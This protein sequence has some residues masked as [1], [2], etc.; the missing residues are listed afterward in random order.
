[1]SIAA[2]ARTTA[3]QELRDAAGSHSDRELVRWVTTGESSTYTDVLEDAALWARRLAAAGVTPGERVVLLLP[4]SAAFVG[5]LFGTWLL[6]AVAVPLNT[7]LRGASLRHPLDLF[8]PHAVVVSAALRPILDEVV[9][10]SVVAVEVDGTGRTD[11]EGVTGEAGSHG[12][13]PHDATMQ[14]ACLIMSTSGTTGPSKGTVWDFGTLHQWVRTY[15]EHLALGPTDRIYCCTPLFH[16][17]S[18]ASGLL[19]ALHVGGTVVVAER[20]SVS[21]FWDDITAS[22]ATTAN[23]LGAMVDLLLADDRPPSPSGLRTM[24]VS[25]CSAR[26]HGAMQERWGITPVT[27]YGLT[28]FGTIVFS[29]RGAEAPPGSVGRPVDGYEVRLVD[30][31]DAA[32]PEG[33]AGELLVRPREAWTAPPGYFRMPE[34]T[35]ES[36]RGLWFHTGDLLRVDDGWWYYVGRV[37]DSMRRRGENVSAHEVEQAALGF[38]PVG[39]AAAYAVPARDSEDDV[40]LAVVLRAGS[41]PLDH[42]AFVTHLAQ[43][44]PYFAVPRFIRVVDALPKTP[45]LRV[46][47]TAL[48]TEGVTDDTWDLERS[49]VTVLRNPRGPQRQR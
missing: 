7:E 22:A 16:A 1:M 38:P 3:L 48:R 42:R 12:A 49:D 11:M 9:A 26:S 2:R 35:L 20:F 34:Q 41:A 24:L 17:N 15:A 28:D 27:A 18:L 44:L 40:A 37:T 23:L 14:D 45:T 19:T 39:E 32:V 30:S 10:S 25:S 46:Q 4:N 47:K 13:P 29:Q 21:G 33:R 6:G 5:A 36:R 31:D 43:D 8:E